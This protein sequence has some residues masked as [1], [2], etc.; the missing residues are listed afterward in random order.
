MCEGEKVGGRKI[1]SSFYDEI[2][3]ECAMFRRLVVTA[4]LRCVCVVS[5]PA[6]LLILASSFFYFDDRLSLPSLPLSL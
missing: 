1:N 6:Q 3:D 5:R 4:E 2:S